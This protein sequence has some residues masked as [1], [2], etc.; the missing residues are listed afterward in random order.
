M[1]N[2]EITKIRMHTIF[3]KYINI[4]EANLSMYLT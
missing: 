2:E 4:I 1:R 3:N